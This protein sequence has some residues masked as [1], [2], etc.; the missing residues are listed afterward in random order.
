M[1]EK[2]CLNSQNHLVRSEHWAISILLTARDCEVS[3][4]ICLNDGVHPHPT[5]DDF[6][7]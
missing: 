5:V 7:L 2:E 6:V 4:E 3:K 1:L